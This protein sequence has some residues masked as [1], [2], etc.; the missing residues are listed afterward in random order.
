M[1]SNDIA[2][3]GALCA[4]KALCHVSTSC[5]PELRSLTLE[6]T[7]RLLRVLSSEQDLSILATVQSA[8][9]QL[10]VLNLALASCFLAAP[11]PPKPVAA[12]ASPPLLHW[13]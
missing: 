9:E 2:S 13:P 6:D 3:G 11:Y 5:A 12:T 4:S 1:S 8:V 7:L 10:V